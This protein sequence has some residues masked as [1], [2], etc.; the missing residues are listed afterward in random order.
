MGS[1]AFKKH[2]SEPPLY[3]LKSWS[4]SSPI[5]RAAEV[6][7]RSVISSKRIVIKDTVPVPVLQE[8]AFLN[9]TLPK[10]VYFPPK[11]WI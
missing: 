8:V 11:L 2:N 3:L 6:S 9:R 10:S 7:Q 1:C 5:N 4:K